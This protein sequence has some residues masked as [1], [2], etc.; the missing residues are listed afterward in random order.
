M[1]T[2][3]QLF[4][5]IPSSII[6]D[7]MRRIVGA[8]SLTPRHASGGLTGSAYTV[9]VR[10]GDNLY[11]H[12]ALR[13][14]QPGQVLVVDGEGDV[15]RALVGEI[16][17]SVAK[18]RGVAGFVIHG[19]IRDSDAFKAHNFPCYAKGITHQGPLKNGPGEQNIPVVIDGCVVNPG[20]IVVGD[21]DGVV[22]IPRTRAEEVAALSRKKIAQETDVLA[23]IAKG[24]YDDT[25]I[26][27][28]LKAQLV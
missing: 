25:W 2:L 4:E 20:D 18:L 11:I 16:M 10:P 17:M 12:D 21:C 1:D 19:A 6:S 28:A 23:G 22:F 14:I 27:A 3:A 15:Q 8:H 5:G 7:S 9:K 13:K 26:D 24:A